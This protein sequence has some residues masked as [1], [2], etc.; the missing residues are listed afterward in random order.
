MDEWMNEI[1]NE[2]EEA[3]R[4]MKTEESSIGTSQHF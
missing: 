3:K 2:K 4:K 1:M